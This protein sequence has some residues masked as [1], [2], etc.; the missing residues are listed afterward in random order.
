MEKDFEF[1]VSWF[2][3]MLNAHL[4]LHVVLEVS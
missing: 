4:I 1:T 3:E 2:G